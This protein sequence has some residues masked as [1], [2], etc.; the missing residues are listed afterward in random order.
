[1]ISTIALMSDDEPPLMDGFDTEHGH[2]YCMQRMAETFNQ[3]FLYCIAERFP[4][5]ISQAE[6]VRDC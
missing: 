5:F 6:G 1:M 3:P 2:E 4:L